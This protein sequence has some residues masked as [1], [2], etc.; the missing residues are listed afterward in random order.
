MLQF[1]GVLFSL[2]LP[3]Q[4]VAAP[5]ILVAS[6]C[7]DDY[8]NQ[9]TLTTTPLTIPTCPQPH[10]VGEVWSLESVSWLINKLTEI[11]VLTDNC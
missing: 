7:I 8:T 6:S 1:S 5:A 3:W 4:P 2:W 11:A 10:R 9:I